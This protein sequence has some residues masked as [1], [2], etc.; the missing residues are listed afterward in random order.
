MVVGAGGAGAS[1]DGQALAASGARSAFARF[2]ADGSASASVEADGGA[3]G[4][5]GA[6]AD[7]AGGGGAMRAARTMNQAG[8][9]W[10][11]FAGRAL[12]SPV[13]GAPRAYAGGGGACVWDEGCSAGSAT[14]GDAASMCFESRCDAHQHSGGGGGAPPDGTRGARRRRAPSSCGTSDVGNQSLFFMDTLSYGP[15]KRT[16]GRPRSPQKPY[17]RSRHAA[18]LVAK[19]VGEA[20]DAVSLLGA[21]PGGGGAG[22]AVVDV[23]RFRNRRFRFVTRF[24]NVFRRKRFFFVAAKPRP[25]REQERQQ[26]VRARAYVEAASRLSPT[27]SAAAAARPHPSAAASS[28]ACRRGR[29]RRATTGT[30]MTS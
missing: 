15:F 13:S 25:F 21:S 20:R 23:A 3:G 10:R 5:A 19:R 28:R 4:T 6:A 26:D 7:A 24:G 27:S 9:N 1:G 29:L 11:N 22:P 18:R 30:S 16:K 14:G 8:Y 17:V 12:V 2:E